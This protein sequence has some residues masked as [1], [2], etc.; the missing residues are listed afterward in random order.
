MDIAKELIKVNLIEELEE[1]NYSETFATQIV[2]DILEPQDP[3]FV[4]TTPEELSAALRVM[5]EG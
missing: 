3:A 5:S 2:E 1:A 4:C